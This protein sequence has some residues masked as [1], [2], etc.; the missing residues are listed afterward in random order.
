MMHPAIFYSIAM[1]GNQ[2]FFVDY[3]TSYLFRIDMDA[4]KIRIESRLG[5][6]EMPEAN[7]YGAI[8]EYNGKLVIAPRNASC[9]LIYDIYTDKYERI[10]LKIDSSIIQGISNLFGS[11]LLSGD[12]VYLF[13]GRYPA[14]VKIDMITKSVSYIDS[15]YAEI[16]ESLTDMQRVIF[17]D[18]RESS[19]EVYLPCWQN[20]SVMTFN[21][22]TEEYTIDRY[23]NLK[24]LSCIVKYKDDFIAAQRDTMNLRMLRTR[25]NIDLPNIEGFESEM[26][27][28]DMFVYKDELYVIPLKA[29]KIIKYSFTEGKWMNVCNI[30]NR[31]TDE[32]SRISWIDNNYLC[33]ERI[34]E[35]LV[36]LSSCYDGKIH[37]LD[38]NEDLVFEIEMIRDVNTKSELPKLTVNQPLQE[39]TYFT[40]DEFIGCVA[41]Q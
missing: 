40:L 30:L 37:C 32:M 14:I 17:A 25:T 29:N 4:R 38:M 11:A 10:N 26:G 24:A 31:P 5:Q 27:I 16:K 41:K 22:G 19:D 3:Y 15:W 2:G 12:S 6:D 21:L 34:G 20:G 9:V 35:N 33:A 39:S 28:K 18:N 7:L 13:P 23:A 1:V 8:A 36:I